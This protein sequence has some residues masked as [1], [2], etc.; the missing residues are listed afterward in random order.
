MSQRWPPCIG[1]I[2]SLPCRLKP[3]T[4]KG[5]PAPNSNFHI[6]GYLKN[7]QIGTFQPFRWTVC[8]AYSVNLSNN[9]YPLVRVSRPWAIAAAAP[10]VHLD[11][12]SS[13]SPP[14]PG[15]WPPLLPR[16]TVPTCKPVQVLPNKARACHCH[17][18]VIFFL[19]LPPNPSNPLHS[20]NGK[21]NF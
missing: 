9:S 5:P 14:P 12:G 4:S 17:L 13:P 16:E 20:T 21:L 10:E 8:F 7:S 3:I 15:L 2:L 19:D 1:P 11:R 6:P 18:T